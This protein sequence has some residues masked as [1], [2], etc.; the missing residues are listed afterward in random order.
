MVWD[1]AEPT[2]SPASKQ[3]SSGPRVRRSP[4]VS[5]GPGCMSCTP[6]FLNGPVQ[7]HPFCNPPQTPGLMSQGIPELVSGGGPGGTSQGQT[8]SARLRP[9]GEIPA[10]LQNGMCRGLR[11]DLAPLPQKCPDPALPPSNHVIGR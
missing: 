5:W 7:P 3:E 9:G 11:E 1:R 8:G 2:P 10:L 6:G 4:T